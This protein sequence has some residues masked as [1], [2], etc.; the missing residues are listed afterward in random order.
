MAQSLR[1]QLR[2][3]PMFQV[4]EG[5]KEDNN[6]I[7]EEFS[8]G[9]P[10]LKILGLIIGSSKSKNLLRL[11]NK[12][13]NIFSQLVKI[14]PTFLEKPVDEWAN[15][16]SYKEIGNIVK[17]LKIVND[18]GKR[19]VRLGCNFSKTLHYGLEQPRIGT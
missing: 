11:S 5:E 8:L 7:A 6:N 18:A 13:F 2:E 12:F 3:S 1:E 14:A 17:G 10:E 4:E 15:N 16:D 19:A 9:K